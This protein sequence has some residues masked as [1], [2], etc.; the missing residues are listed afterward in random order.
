[1]GETLVITQLE[2]KFLY[3]GS[4]KLDNRVSAAKHEGVIG[5]VQ[6]LQTFSSQKGKNGR[7][8]SLSSTNQFQNPAGKINW[9]SKAW[10]YL[11]VLEAP[12]PT[13]RCSASA[14][15]VLPSVPKALWSPR[16]FLWLEDSMCLQLNSSNSLFPVCRILGV[17]ELSFLL[18]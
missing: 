4:V 10:E 16:S 15:V 18:S 7:K 8:E 3:F 5:I 2:A 11:A 14:P 12:G 17:W 1:M 6:Q 13:V 9:C